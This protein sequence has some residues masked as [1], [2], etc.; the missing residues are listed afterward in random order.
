MKPFL[1]LL[2][3]IA[4]TQLGFGQIKIILIDKKDIPASIHYAGHVINAAHYTDKEGAHIIIA[5]ETGIVQTKDKDGEE[6][7]KA[8]LYAYNYDI[9]GGKQMLS[10]QM[11]D[12]SGECGLDLEANYVTKTFTITD[13]NNDGVAE[14]W[15]VYRTACTGD[16]SPPVMKIIMHEGNKKYAVRGT[17]KVKV[18]DKDYAGGE[19]TLDQ[20]LK[21]GPDLFKQYALQLWKKNIMKTWK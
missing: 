18:S 5:T 2:L 21:A 13:L 3:A 9:N 12:M 6:V 10:W 1:T 20:A 17:A 8:D 7:R 11:H 4:F 14:V 19:Y 16:V 15:L